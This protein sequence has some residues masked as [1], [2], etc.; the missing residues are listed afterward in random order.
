MNQTT[1]RK[2]R[3]L[4]SR[5]HLDSKTLWFI[6]RHP[7]EIMRLLRWLRQQSAATMS[8]RSPWWPYNAIDWMAATL[9]PT[10]HVFEYGGGGSTLWLEDRGAAVTVAEHDRQ[11]YEQ[12]SGVLKPGTRLLFRPSLASGTITS[13]VSPGYF[14]A[15]VAAIDSEPDSSLD[16]VVIDGRA[17]VE[18][19]RHAMP[20]VKP[21]GLLLFDDTDRAR[22]EPAI[23]M[24][25]T[26]ERRVFAGLKAG[27][28][29]PAQTSV[30]K[31]PAG[32]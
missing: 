13:V 29:H 15:Y 26:W 10:A 1:I 28:R 11:W 25:S 12:L 27:Q 4:A 9:P 19:A 8:L 14:D 5:I 24:L 2:M 32:G 7:Q 31:R 22:Y 17:R 16:L 21:G 30:W 3:R 20:K 18:S 23:E 6:T